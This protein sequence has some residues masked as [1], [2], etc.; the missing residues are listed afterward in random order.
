L[1]LAVPHSQV[2]QEISAGKDH[3][4][5]VVISF[6]VTEP[7]VSPT[8]SLEYSLR[9]SS[10]ALLRSGERQHRRSRQHDG[11]R[12]KHVVCQE[13]RSSPADGMTVPPS[14]SSNQG[15]KEMDS[16]RPDPSERERDS[17]MRFQP[18]PGTL[19]IPDNLCVL[20]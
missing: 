9:F 16:N 5:H 20:Q 18:N 13:T 12:L 4:L 17:S 1:L 15:P 11:E 19:R 14:L 8:A 10:G 6:V 2:E 7:P 3:V